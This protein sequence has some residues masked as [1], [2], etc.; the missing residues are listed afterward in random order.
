MADAPS[1]RLLALALKRA[2]EL[3]ADQHERGKDNFDT[4]A[5]NAKL[6]KVLEPELQKLAMKSMRTERVAG[7]DEVKLVE[8]VRAAMIGRAVQVAQA[9]NA[10]TTNWLAGQE[11]DPDA[12]FGADRAVRAG[13]TESTWVHN[14]V[15]K[16][17]GQLAKHTKKRWRNG[18]NP[19]PECRSLNGK[20]IKINAT[21]RSKGGIEA[22]AP[23]LHPHC[24]CDLETLP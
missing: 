1:G 3:Q 24:Y 8:Q 4:G 17:V 16:V 2:F 12:V 18:P 10:A 21:F 9:I 11:P 15:R 19:C 5:W 23:P 14:H 6:S 22:Q 20:T 7:T 13:E